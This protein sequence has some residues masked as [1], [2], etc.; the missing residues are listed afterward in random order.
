MRLLKV[1]LGKIRGQFVTLPKYMLSVYTQPE[2]YLRTF[3]KFGQ[4]YR[5]YW[6]LMAHV[7]SF[8]INVWF[9]HTE[10]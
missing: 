9:S 5:G 10:R 3:W 1:E 8:H 2:P 7:G 4:L 6:G